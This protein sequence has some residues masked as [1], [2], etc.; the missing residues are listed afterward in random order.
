[1]KKYIVVFLLCFFILGTNA[2]IRVK[3]YNGTPPGN[4]FS[5]NNENIVTTGRGRVENVSIPEIVVYKPTTQDEKKPAVVIC[6]GGGFTSLSIFDGGYQ[7]AEELN[8][9]G[10]VAIVLKY[11][12]FINQFYADYK[13]CPNNDVERAFEIIKDSALVWHIDTTNTGIMGLSAGGHLASMKAVSK[14]GFKTAFNFLIYPVISFRDELT[15]AKT[16]SR[17]VLLGKDP[18]EN[19]KNNFSAELHVSSSTK[20]CFIVHAQNDST[21]LVQ[22]SLAF[23]NAL[24]KNKVKSEMIIYQ[25]GGHGFAS[26]NK[27][28]DIGWMPM[29]I[30]W[31]RANDFLRK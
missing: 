23:Y 7:I 15:S 27:E 5:V 11:R 22:N 25:Y 18:T 1:L 6:P 19:E 17:S 2:Q 21:V 9:Y 16:K 14:V 29:A 10:I 28:Q 30:N 13:K 31:L 8:K 4:L 20:P 3:L 24:V 26:Y 12:T